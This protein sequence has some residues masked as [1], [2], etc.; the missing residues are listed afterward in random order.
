MVIYLLIYLQLWEVLG[1]SQD[2]ITL[3]EEIRASQ[4]VQEEESGLSHHRL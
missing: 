4:V 3:R 1:S 2:V